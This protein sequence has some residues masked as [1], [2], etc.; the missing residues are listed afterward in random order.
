MSMWFYDIYL[1]LNPLQS[2]QEGGCVQEVEGWIKP[3]QV[4]QSEWKIQITY[5]EMVK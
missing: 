2:P 1:Y 5:H 3:K 4:I